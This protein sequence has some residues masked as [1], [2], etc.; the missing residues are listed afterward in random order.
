MRYLLTEDQ[1]R[2]AEAGAVAAGATL[3][4]LMGKAGAAVAAEV[5]ALVADG[6]VVVAAGAGN[7]GGDGWVTAQRLHESGRDVLV[8]TSAEPDDMSSPAREAVRD[9]IEAGVPWLHVDGYVDAAAA[10]AGATIVVDALLGIGLHGTPLQPYADL[11]RAI[12]DSSAPVVAIDVPSGVDSDT[13][14]TLG[15]A[16]QADVTVTFS[17]PKV[18]CVLQPGASLSGE[19]VVADIG[20]DPALLRFD[21]APESW[22]VADYAQC[23]PHP[24]WDDRKGTRGRVLVIG[25]TP[26]L[27]GAVCLAAGGALRSGAGYVSVAV[28]E[29]A[30]RVIEVKLTAPVKMALPSDADGALL[31]AA[32]DAVL[33]ASTR[34]DAVVLGPGLGR[35]DSTCE[36]VRALVA[37]LEIPLLID[38]DALYALSDD[39]SGI[40]ARIAPTV[41]TPHSAEAARLLGTTPELVDADRPAAVRKLAVGSVTAVLKGPATLIAEGGRTVVNSTG[42]PGLATLGTGDVLSGIVGALLAR[43][44]LP[45]DA[46]VVGT[47]LHG[48]SGD[49]A[50]RDLTAVC[51]TA[52]DI[53]AYLPQAVRPL[54][55]AYRTN[56]HWK[57][58]R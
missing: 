15:P 31:P 5:S 30:M 44:M 4:G 36:V 20:I 39:L 14:V 13:G 42:G 48:A 35:A 58:A 40:A 9:A 52:E 33:D 32:V 8:L 17:A 6:R 24:H 47:Y 38:A 25:G 54:M 16:V 3:A 23:L 45:I 12:S 19:L 46:A 10:L 51:C 21:G 37:R 2:T 53:V 56:T 27:T 57:D 18:G 43:G 49:A 55:D 29:P 7:N 22:D 11:I 1:A 34:A 41:L 28:P 50:T 26:G